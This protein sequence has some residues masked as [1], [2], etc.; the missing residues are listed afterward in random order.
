[1]VKCINSLNQVKFQV[2]IN[3]I[4][5]KDKSTLRIQGKQS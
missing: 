2:L 4:K 5:R 1:M 3:K